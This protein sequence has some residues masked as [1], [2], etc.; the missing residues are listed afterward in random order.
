MAGQAPNA[1]IK[2][3]QKNAIYIFFNGIKMAIDDMN[4]KTLALKA[5]NSFRLM[6]NNPSCHDPYFIHFYYII[7]KLFF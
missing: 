1:I 2:E 5:K 4:V 3:V 7:L 6:K